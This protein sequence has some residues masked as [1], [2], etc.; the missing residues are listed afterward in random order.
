MD[1]LIRYFERPGNENTDDLINLVKERLVDSDIKYVAIASV[2]GGTALKLFK[3]LEDAGINDKI[4][5][6]VTH[7][8]GFKEKNKLEISSKTRKKLEEKG[9]ITFAGSHAFSGVGRGI[10]NKFGGVTPVEII[11]ETFRMFSQGIKVCG[12]ISIM[13]ADAGLIPVEEK[14]L[15][16]GG[17][18]IGADSAAI[19]TPANMTNVFDMRIHE[20]IA[21]PID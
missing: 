20:I 10:S 15:A 8:A 5:V 2:S 13:L 17:R 19:I 7:H 18:A 4:I 3:A 6:N 11:A 12:E 9:I 1:K 14:I 16:I 21:M